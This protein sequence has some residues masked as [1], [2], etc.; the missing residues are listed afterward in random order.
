MRLYMYHVLFNRLNYLCSYLFVSTCVSIY[1]F[2]YLCTHNISEDAVPENIHPPFLVNFP[3]HEHQC[4]MLEIM[5][6]PIMRPIPFL[7]S[8]STLSQP[9]ERNQHHI[10]RWGQCASVVNSVLNSV[11][12]CAC[13][14]I[15][16]SNDARVCM[17]DD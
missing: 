7:H 14:S 16:L 13:V 12:K 10:F 11:N 3:R 9:L 4:G 15:S 8:I 2:M 1:P 5:S 6:T 17:F